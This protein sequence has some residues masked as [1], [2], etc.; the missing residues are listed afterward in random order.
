MYANRTRNIIPSVSFR[1]LLLTVAIAILTGC[2]GDVVNPVNDNGLAIWRLVIDRPSV[3]MAQGET[4]KLNAIPRG[5][6]GVE[7]P[8]HG[9]VKWTSSDLTSVT[10]DDDGTLHAIAPGNRI[11]V[12]AV[13]SDLVNN[14][15]VR[16]TSYVMVTPTVQPIS[17]FGFVLPQGAP[18]EIAAGQFGL[19]PVQAM[20]G[21]TPL[22]VPFDYTIEGRNKVVTFPALNGINV[23]GIDTGRVMFRTNMYAYGTEYRD[24]VEYTVTHPVMATF[25]IMDRALAQAMISTQPGIVNIPAVPGDYWFRPLRFTVKQGAMVVWVNYSGTGGGTITPPKLPPVTVNFDRLDGIVP[26]EH[27]SAPQFTQGAPAMRQ[28]T[29]IGTYYWTS[30]DSKQSGSITVVP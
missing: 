18:R 20:S 15:T 11:E 13:L 27:V 19:I 6:N 17:S 23:A 14:I 9:V 22:T 12:I 30:P 8:T 24:S 16:D 4:L 3:V 2:S 1:I 7:V 10:V 26:A 21:S 29:K 25:L 5:L 28:F